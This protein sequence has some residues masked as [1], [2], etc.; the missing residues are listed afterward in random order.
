[1][2][3]KLKRL[4]NEN[5]LDYIK[6]IVYGKL[7]DKT[8]DA[9]YE[10]L[11]EL[12]FGEGNNY[13]SSE[14]RKRFYGI[15]R[16]LELI[17]ENKTENITDNEVLTELQMKKIEIEK[18]R[19]KLQT[20]KLFNNRLVRDCAKIE[21]YLEKIEECVNNLEP[22]DRHEIHIRPE[23]NKVAIIN[24]SDAHVGK[25]GKII[26]LKGEIL[27]EYNFEIFKERMFNLFDE[28]LKIVQRENISEI[29]LLALGDM[30][31]GILRASQLQS[32]EFGVVDS[33]IE[34]SEFI[35]EWIDDLSN[36][37]YI[38]Y[39]S[40]YGNHAGLR[41]L[42]AKSSK[43]FPHENVEKLIDRFIKTRLRNND[44]VRINDNN[45]PYA[46]FDVFGINI[47]AIHGEE[48]NLTQSLKDFRLMYKEDIDII[49]TGHLH[50]NYSQD[51]GIG[52]YG[53]AEVIRV[54]SIC[55]IDDFSMT[56]HKMSRAGSK[57]LIIEDGV[58][59]TIE[60]SVYLN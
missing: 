56:L 22:F 26:G 10:D 52:K 48:K 9:D 7:V 25:E 8:I 38:D 30:V 1:M 42:N 46:Y 49:L 41:L 31:D 58:G 29:K 60:Y 6:R 39:H 14:V 17:E 27:N 35:S 28:V 54:P 4:P 55:G 40:A 16:I 45:L 12:V 5:E 15:K 50:S 23:G 18:E 24:I 32:L 33:V 34:Y 53:N 21:L 59:K 11:S 2:E 3:D 20:E 44:N 36:Y 47:F 43:D 13:N 51:V 57:I 37:V 19:K